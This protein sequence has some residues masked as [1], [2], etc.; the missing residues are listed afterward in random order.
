MQLMLLKEN[1]GE[2]LKQAKPTAEKLITVVKIFSII[3]YH[4]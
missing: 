4:I 3:E 2:G 1:M